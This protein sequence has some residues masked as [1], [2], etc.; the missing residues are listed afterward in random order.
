VDINSARGNTYCQ[1]LLIYNTNR[2]AFV[3]GKIFKTV[4]HKSS[5]AALANLEEISETN[6][7]RK[8]PLDRVES[9]LH[10]VPNFTKA[11]RFYV[12]HFVH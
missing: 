6:L 5:Q 4:H 1:V 9:I 12:N 10:I 7:V 8:F 11:N 3:I 2:G